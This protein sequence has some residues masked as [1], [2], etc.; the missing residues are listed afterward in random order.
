MECTVPLR[1][2]FDGSTSPRHASPDIHLPHPEIY[3]NGSGHHGSLEDT[4]TPFP[5]GLLMN[6]SEGGR[7]DDEVCEGVENICQHFV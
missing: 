5:L 1:T 4:L 3:D 6:M 7:G 2:Q